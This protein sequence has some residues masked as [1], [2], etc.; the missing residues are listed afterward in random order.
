MHNSNARMYQNV[1][2]EFFFH[3]YQDSCDDG[4]KFG[5]HAPAET[6]QLRVPLPNMASVG[7]PAN[8]GGR[9]NREQVQ[10]WEKEVT[11][12]VMHDA[13]PELPENNRNKDDV[14]QEPPDDKAGEELD[15]DDSSSSSSSSSSYS[16]YSRFESFIFPIENNINNF[17]RPDNLGVPLK[18]I[19]LY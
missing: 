10:S 19:L 1:V 18:I 17:K 15:A 11:A 16:S 6:R 7:G 4:P 12:A 14:M 8:G 3:V 2:F 9:L 13:R 5:R